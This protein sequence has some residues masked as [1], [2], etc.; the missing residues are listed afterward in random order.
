MFFAKWSYSLFPQLNLR[1]RQQRKL[2]YASTAH[3]SLLMKLE[4][5]SEDVWFWICV[6]KQ[7][8]PSPTFTSLAYQGRAR[9][10]NRTIKLKNLSSTS[11]WERNKRRWW[12]CGLLID[13][14]DNNRCGKKNT[15]TVFLWPR[16]VTKIL[17]IEILI[18]VVTFLL[19][20]SHYNFF[21]LILQKMTK[22]PIEAR[23]NFAVGFFLW[24][25]ISFWLF[26]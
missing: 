9:I 2:L 18:G 11:V 17:R 26:Q 1:W 23:K 10:G 5:R 3:P 4:L 13:A 14:I 16:I 25:S 24:S 22:S 20:I 12:S 7:T 8:K 21:P 15:R 19:L 6:H